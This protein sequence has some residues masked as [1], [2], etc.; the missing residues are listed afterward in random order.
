MHPFSGAETTVKHRL[1]VGAGHAR[2]RA[3]KLERL[4][5]RRVLDVFLIP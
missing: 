2:A 1:E 3:Q 5:W 4:L